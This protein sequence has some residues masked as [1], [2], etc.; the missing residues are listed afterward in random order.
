MVESQRPER[1][2]GMK[3]PARTVLGHVLARLLPAWLA[4]A[5]VLAS[6]LGL[7]LVLRQHAQMVQA[8]SAQI[9]AAELLL[10]DVLDMETGLRGYAL[11]GEGQFLEP[12][13]RATGVL[14]QHLKGARQVLSGRPDAAAPL[15]AVNQAEALI[16]R[17]REEYVAPLLSARQ[18]VQSAVQAL[19]LS[20]TG[21]NLVDQVRV[22][23]GELERLGQLQ[24][25]EADRRIGQLNRLWFPL[26]TSL[27]VLVLLFNL[28]VLLRLATEIRQ[29]VRAIVSEADGEQSLPAWLRWRETDEVRDR[30]KTR[31]NAVQGQL[32][33][34][35]K[36]LRRSD[37][38]LGGVLNAM[39]A[40]LW[41]FDSH[42][43]VRRINRAGLEALRIPA[44]LNSGQL[45]GNQFEAG[46]FEAG[47]FGT[48]QPLEQLWPE[49][50][51]LL[52]GLPGDL[53]TE[54]QLLPTP[55]GERWYLLNQEALEGGKLLVLTDVT[56][57][58]NSRRALEDLN[59]N[60][61]RSNTDLEHYAFVASHDLQEPLRTIASFAGLLLM[62]QQD[63]LDERGQ[64]YAR[65]VIEGAERL[66]RLIQDLLSFAKVRAE[67][68]D[69]SLVDM[70]RVTEEVLVSLQEEVR[71]R[72]TS[73][74]VGRLPT[75]LGRESLLT[76]LLFNLLQNALKFSREDVPGR[77]SLTGS[78]AGERATF[79]VED[80]GI[81]IAPEYQEQ[82]F[83]IFQR[84]H[85]RG[86]YPGN[87][88]G[89]AI[90]RRITELHGGQLWLESVEGQGSRFHFTLPAATLP[91][92]PGQI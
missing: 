65:N 7:T 33:Q 50:A 74:T 62:T 26:L 29:G 67:Q 78:V 19:A 4:L 49:L 30:V 79:V 71:Q 20:K 9:N 32:E 60:L 70:N 41:A 47:Q 57:L 21:K 28:G 82:V 2:L 84:L 13:Q 15:R 80:N 51:A 66:K 35:R 37:L 31:V 48:G 11:T 34:E 12:Y 83:V 91:S 75:V 42:G 88:L 76:Q 3:R 90:C 25:T 89:L 64:F 86:R 6:L 23:L 58:Q 63:R 69:F 18:P 16:A 55:A 46:Q 54:P 8:A 73:I 40:Q 61:T 27:A 52:K 14:E 72:G 38:T 59:Q 5:L 68:L 43:L 45:E 17:W 53:P 87:G 1:V 24:A 92:A 10:S 36:Q 81:G 85:G 39:T 56:Q 44:T 77:V 22:Q